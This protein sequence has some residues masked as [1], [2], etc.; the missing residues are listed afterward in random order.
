MLHFCETLFRDTIKAIQFP[1]H[2]ST[3]VAIMLYV[4]IYR[5]HPLPLT[6]HVPCDYHMT[7]YAQ[8]HV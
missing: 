8:C 4:D 5:K 6:S 2:V 1:I 3:Y 7:T